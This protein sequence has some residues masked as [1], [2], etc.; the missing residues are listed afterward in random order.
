VLPPLSAP[1]PPPYPKL[2]RRAE[3]KIFGGV[4]AGIADHLR[5]PVLAVRI[6][7]LVLLLVNFSGAVLYAVFWAVLSVDPADRTEGRSSRDTGQFVAFLALAVGAVLLMLTV[8]GGNGFEF[9]WPAVVVIL[10]VGV[11]WH[12][13]DPARRERWSELAPRLPWL[14]VLADAGERLESSGGRMQTTTRLVS[15]GLLVLV[16][17]I[18]FLAGSG[19]LVAAREGLLFGGV[20]VAGMAVVTAP[21]IWR[22]VVELRAERA[23]RIRSQTRADIAAVVHDQ[24]LHT[25]AL[26]QRNADDPREVARLARGQERELR[27][28]LYKPAASST[29]R[30]AAALEAV[31]AEVEDAY[32][33]NVDVVVVGDCGVDESLSAMVMAAREALINAGKHAGVL[34]VSL[35]AEVEPGKASVFVRDR[36]AGFAQSIVDDD[37][38]G[39]SGSIV[40]RMRRHGGTARILS[41]PGE[42]T[43]VRLSMP[44]DEA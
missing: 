8:V 36:G 11:I 23:E 33:V 1:V 30:F 7:F 22:N 21:W 41:E 34:A 37:R 24:V 27:Q 25:L 18:G 20:L 15:G 9:A 19:E 42:G 39:V 12:R 35:Y 44:R 2:R 29:E 43:E 14:G 32:A 10:G 40:G 16:G 6:A 26:I 3:G 13:A 31:A 28:W 17:L 4:A 5:V 38:H